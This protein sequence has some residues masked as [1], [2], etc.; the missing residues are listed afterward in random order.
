MRVPGR[1]RLDDE[2]DVGLL[3]MRG[4]IV[5][6][7]QRMV[8]GK[9]HVV[10]AGILEDRRAQRLR[11]LDQR[12]HGKGIPPRGLGDD[13][14]IA[15]AGE[16]LR[17]VVDVGRR[18]A[19]QARLLQAARLRVLEGLVALGEHF[20]RQREVDGPGRLGLRHGE[21]AV[22]HG[23]DLGE[24][25]QL[26]VPLHE[27]A[28][29]ARLVVGLLRPVDVAV[30]AAEDA[31]LGKR[32][33]AGREEDGHLRPRGIDDAA[34]G[35][36]GADDHVHHHRLRPPRDHG[37][38]VGHRH[39]RHLVG[40]GDRPRQGLTLGP[41]LGIGLDDRREVRAGIGEEVLDAARCQQLEVCLGG[42]LDRDSLGHHTLPS[43][44]SGEDFSGGPECC[45]SL[46]PPDT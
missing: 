12:G 39:R 35:I 19:K 26:V 41:A 8:A 24:V 18:G 2:D 17:R 9:V 32:R 13:D 14:R 28:R 31:P 22:H 23:L 3:E 38:A 21:R 6:R 25:A 10:V 11:E 40:H 30:A 34:E 15:R 27:L 20:A 44:T 46:A 43:V 33:A 7:V 16:E 29:H 4:R 5:A 42:A 36:G 45:G 1:V 37:I